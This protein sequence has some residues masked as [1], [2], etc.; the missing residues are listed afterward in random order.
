MKQHILK[1]IIKPNKRTATQRA[2]LN[3]FIMQGEATI[4][5]LSKE[6]GVSIPTVTKSLNELIDKGLVHE[7][8][9]RD[10][11]SGRIP[12]IYNLIPSSGYFIGIDPTIDSLAFGICD[13]CGNM[14]YRKTGIPY[15]YSDTPEC[16]N[17]L[18][19][20]LREFIGE[21]TID[22]SLIYGVCM[23]VAERVNIN[24]GTAYN[25]YTFLEKPL[26]QAL[27]DAIGYPV[28]IENDS[29][30]MTYAEYLQGCCRGE[31]NVVFVNIGWGLGMGMVIDGKLYS[32]KSGYSGEIGHMSVY[33][34][35]IICH[36]GKLG[37][38]ETE[39]S[40]LALQRKLTKLLQEGGQSILSDKVVN[41]KQTLTLQDIL[42]AI[43]REDV[44]CIEAL[45]KVADEL[46]KNLAGVI[47]IFNPDLLV[48]GGDLSVTGDY[49]IQPVRMGIK[50]YSLNV[51]N[52]DS[53]VVVSDLKEQA[54]LVG[55]CLMARHKILSEN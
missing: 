6:L 3:L 16:L 15:H 4:P 47:N 23:N 33:D 25:K 48:I 27:T 40:G 45:Q 38:M 52:E 1:D 53:R 7:V 50:K 22:K 26:A 2:L 19:N 30:S 54:G 11:S 46:G 32:G 42:D 43:A 41:Q 39:V 17:S 24:E 13:F 31:K 14:V 28:Y 10:N 51:V 12:T 34:N 21:L 37:C 49:L 35:D 20:M 29:R 5:E 18:V 55:A 44:L 36:C 8:G 9:K